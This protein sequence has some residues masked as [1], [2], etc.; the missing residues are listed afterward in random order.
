VVELALLLPLIVALLFGSWEVG[1]LVH[2]QQ[3]LSNAACEGGRQAST[4][5]L[6]NTSVQQVVSGYLQEAGIPTQNVTVTV[7]NLTTPGTDARSASQLDQ[8]RVTVSVPFQDV[9]WIAL[10]YFV[11]SDTAVTGQATWWS[12]KDRD[13]PSSPGAPPGY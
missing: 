9:R 1:R 6:G 2:V 12:V 3:M 4:G 8:L 5:Q 13:Y 10:N 11:A 7:E